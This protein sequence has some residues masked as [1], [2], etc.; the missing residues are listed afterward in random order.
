MTAKEW[1]DSGKFI[2]IDNNNIFVIDTDPIASKKETIVIISGYPLNSFDYSQIIDILKDYY[3]VI[4]HD[5]LGFGFSDEPEEYAYSLMNQANDCVKL[6][7]K[8]KLKDFT[9]LASQYGAMVAKEILHKKNYNLISF[10]IR[11]VVITKNNSDQLYTSLNTIYYLNSNKHLPKY[12]EVLANCSDKSLF[13]SHEDSAFNEKYKDDE[14]VRVIWENFK[15]KE[16][17]KDFL[18]LSS[19]NE[20]KFLYWHRWVNALKDSK[21][22][23]HYF[24]RKD[25]LTN[26]VSYPQ[27]RKFYYGRKQ[28]LL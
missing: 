25:D 17:Q 5:H 7:C 4:I 1:K 26:I 24:W 18:I 12:K 27:K 11:E 21:V 23:V 13:N 9:I 8:L 14:K 6:Y 15:T 3:R 20:E 2:N 22:R 16:K 19:Y 10:N 28:K